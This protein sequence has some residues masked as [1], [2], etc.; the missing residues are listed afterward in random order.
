MVE[1]TERALLGGHVVGTIEGRRCRF[2]RAVGRV[3]E[4][5][6]T[7]LIRPPV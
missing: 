4:A 1:S 6:R 3:A 2:A 5:H 7:A